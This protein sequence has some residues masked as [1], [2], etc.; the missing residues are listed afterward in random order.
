MQIDPYSARLILPSR[1]WRVYRIGK[2]GEMQFYGQQLQQAD[3]PCF[4]LKIPHIQNIKVYQVKYFSQSSKN[5]N[6]VCMSADHQLGSLRFS[7]S[8]VTARV[9]GLLPIFEE[10]VDINVRGKLE[11]KTQTQDYAH[12]CDLHLPERNSILR[13]YDSGYEFQQGLEISPNATQNTIRINW[14][15][16]IGWINQNTPHSQVWSE[17]QP[18]GETVL[19]QTETLNQI[20][21]NIQLYRRENSNWDSAFHLY[22]GI[23]F[24]KNAKSK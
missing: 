14:N 7:W 4:W 8:E 24:V 17:F 13:I 18:F 20:P 23:I 21:A 12:F 15:N 1:C 5:P 22:S 9:M 19:D 6:A 10:V 16:L 11:R 3:I 2:I